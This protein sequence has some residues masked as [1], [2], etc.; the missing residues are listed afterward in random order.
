MLDLN[1]F[2]YF[3]EVVDRNGFS[4]AGRAL[5]IPTSTTALTSQLFQW[6]YVKLVVVEEFATF[7]ATDVAVTSD[8]QGLLVAVS[9]ALSA[10][11]RF[12]T[13]SAVARNF[14]G[15]KT[16]GCVTCATGERYR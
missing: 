9:N 1:D 3:V 10:E 2:R 16:T 7:G 4:A 5:G 12:A 13:A 11:V 15:N 6:Q 8:E 14:W